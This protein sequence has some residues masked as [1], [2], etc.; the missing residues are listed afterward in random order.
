MLVLKLR[1][2]P[3]AHYLGN[4][5]NPG[6]TKTTHWLRMSLL[7]TDKRTYLRPLAFEFCEKVG[8]ESALQ[9]CFPGLPPNPPLPS[10]K[11]YWVQLQVTHDHVAGPQYSTRCDEW[12]FQGKTVPASQSRLA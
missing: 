4:T 1:P 5:G 8:V 12:I 9:R 11:T 2:D 6:L 7:R 10:P 3:A